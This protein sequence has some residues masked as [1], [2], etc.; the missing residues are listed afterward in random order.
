[1]PDVQELVEDY[2]NAV[3]MADLRNKRQETHQ[4]I[5]RRMGFRA[6]SQ[7]IIAQVR[8]IL[9]NLDREI[10]FIIGVKY[11]NKDIHKMAKK[12]LNRVEEQTG[13][14]PV[15]EQSRRGEK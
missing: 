9:H 10:G 12:L 7:E 11:D 14:K 13:I 3:I 8:E 6:K 5:L 2:L 1:M 15:S 4:A